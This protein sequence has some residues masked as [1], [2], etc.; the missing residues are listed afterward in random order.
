ME[1]PQQ[2]LTRWLDTLPLA[3]LA[4]IAGWL[5]LAPV[6]PEPHLVEKLRMLRQGLLVKP[7]D[8]FDLLMHALPLVLV[9]AKLWR[10]RWLHLRKP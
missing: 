4:L 7:L 8:V 10:M 6:F 3:W 2:L 9:L 1:T 5:A